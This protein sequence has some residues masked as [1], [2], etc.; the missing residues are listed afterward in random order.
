MKLYGGTLDK[1]S[2]DTLHLEG[3]KHLTLIDMPSIDLRNVF[4]TLPELQTFFVR[5]VD[6][7]KKENFMAVYRRFI[8]YSGLETLGLEL[9]PFDL[10]DVSSEFLQIIQFHSNSL[11]HLY[12]GRNKVPSSLLKEICNKLMGG[13]QVLETIDLT[14]AK[15]SSKIDWV[16]TFKD[17]AKLSAQGRVQPIIVRVSDYQTTLKRADI[18][19]YLEDHKPNIEVQFV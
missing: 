4:E 5:N 7:F 13:L 8:S 16:D 11:K 18:Y 15:E 10:T 1:I 14:H 3:T 6:E 9:L 2:I 17:I 12:I 19:K